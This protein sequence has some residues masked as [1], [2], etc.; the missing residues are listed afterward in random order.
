MLYLT[1]PNLESFLDI[2]ASYPQ[3]K[4]LELILEADSHGQTVLHHLIDEPDSLLKIINL[5]S[6]NDRMEALNLNDLRGISPI[7]AFLPNKQQ[8]QYLIN[9]LS[10]ENQF[11]ISLNCGMVIDNPSNAQQRKEGHEANDES[12]ASDETRSY[13]SP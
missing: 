3:D 12:E 7:S 8:F 9:S 10:K 4:R 5:L 2:I 6:E 1:T 13:L 11:K